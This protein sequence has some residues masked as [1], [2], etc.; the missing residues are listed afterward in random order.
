MHVTLKLIS[1]YDNAVELANY[2][3][4]SCFSGF[5][6]VCQ[7]YCKLTNSSGYI[8]LKT[9]YGDRKL[10]SHYFMMIHGSGKEEPEILLG[11][12][13]C[14]VDICYSLYSFCILNTCRQAWCCNCKY[15]YIHIYYLS[16]AKY[17]RLYLWS[18]D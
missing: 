9:D 13:N 10:F 12:S 1:F 5:S 17:G 2:S 16:H 18:Y 14:P 3:N 6:S 15:T 7:V 8:F 4:W 11:A